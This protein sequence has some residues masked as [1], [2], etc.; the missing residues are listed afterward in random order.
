MGFRTRTGSRGLRITKNPYGASIEIP[1]N[2]PFTRYL[3][4]DQKELE[5]AMKTAKMVDMPSIP[6]KTSERSK[7]IRG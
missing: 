2:D 6:R 5:R 1:D 3:P 7:A 4:P